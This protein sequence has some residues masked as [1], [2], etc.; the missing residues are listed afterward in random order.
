MSLPVRRGAPRQK[1]TSV[2]SGSI[3][4]AHHSHPLCTRHLPNLLIDLHPGR[5]LYKFTVLF[6]YTGSAMNQHLIRILNDG[7]RETLVW[8]C[9]HVGDVRV[10]AAARHLEAA[11]NRTSPP[12]VAIWACVRRH[13]RASIAGPLKTARSAIAISPRSASCSHNGTRLR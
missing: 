7:D 9:K 1:A 8:L 5:I 2:Q 12:S 11:A 10:A 4:F 13:R 6:F 3:D